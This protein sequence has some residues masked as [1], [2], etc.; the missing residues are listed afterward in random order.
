MIA[1]VGHLHDRGYILGKI[2]PLP[3]RFRRPVVADYQDIFKRQGRAAANESLLML[4][5]L[6]RLAWRMSADDGAL[7]NFAKR[8]ARNCGKAAARAGERARAACE[9]ITTGAGIEAPDGPKITEAGAVARMGCD[10]WWRRGVRKT[11]GKG[12]EAVAVKIGL[13]HSRAGLYCSDETLVRR[14]GQKTR[15]RL[16][17]EAMQAVNELGQEY[18]LAELADISVSNPAI[19]RGELMTRIA[20]FELLADQLGHVGEFYTF[21]C[22]SRMHARHHKGGA[23]NAK[24]DGTTPREAQQYL[25]QVWA[26]VRAALHRRDVSVYGFRVAEPQHDGTPH[27]HLLLFMPAGDRDTVREL[28]ARYCLQTDGSEPGAKKYRF[29]AVAMDKR[30]GTAAGYIAKYIAKNIDGYGVDADLFGRDPKASAARVDAWA[31]TWGIRQFQQIGGPSVTVWRELRRLGD[32]GELVGILGDAAKCA[33]SGDWAG[34]VKAMG[35]TR[36]SRCERPIQLAK[37][38]AV[39]SETG[40]LRMNRYGEPGA[41]QVYGVECG[42]VI[43]P[44][45]VHK[46]RIERGGNDVERIENRPDV[47]HGLAVVGGLGT[48]SGQPL[49]NMSDVPE[50]EW[51]K[52]LNR[53]EMGE[54]ARA[55]F[56][57]EAGIADPWSPVNNCTGVES[58]TQNRGPAGEGETGKRGAAGGEA[59]AHRGGGGLA[60]GFAGGNG[61]SH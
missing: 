39:D 37:R 26:R 28:C 58:A 21:T 42:S 10:L 19:R 31:S 29:K 53:K 54:Q 34:F 8:Q 61:R 49:K 25:Q 48:P 3:Y 20:G 5:D 13:V 1:G 23:K 32:G 27:W 47:G 45:R 22:P 60:V 35:G 17:L 4:D 41:D 6:P 18:T 51:L 12:V 44:T 11:H 40:E 16:M 56:F 38:G 43:V 52:I 24:Y 30:R 36:I 33:D 14:Q 2:E 55:E 9:Q 50:D 59:W 57:A 15:N 46:W 7:V